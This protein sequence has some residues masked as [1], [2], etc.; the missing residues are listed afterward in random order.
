LIYGVDG[1]LRLDS[2]DRTEHAAW[3]RE[4]DC[5]GERFAQLSLDKTEDIFESIEQ[6]EAALGNAESISRASVENRARWQIEW[7]NRVMNDYCS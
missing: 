2:N 4:I 7:F 3:L 6:I 1:Y 5:H